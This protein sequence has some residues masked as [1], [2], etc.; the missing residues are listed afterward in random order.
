MEFVTHFDQL[1]ADERNACMR[2][3]GLLRGELFRMNEKL[4]NL[5]MQSR[6]ALAY[7][8]CCMEERLEGITED[9]LATYSD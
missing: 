4:E 8:I 5:P 1:T 3:L 6:V 9:L 2:L 7:S